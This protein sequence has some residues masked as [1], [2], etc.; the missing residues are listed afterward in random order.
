MANGD[1]N[2]LQIAT[3]GVVLSAV[4]AGLV[5][6]DSSVDDKVAMERRA[7]L[8]EGRTTAQETLTNRLEDGI[9]TE[10]ERISFF[11]EWAVYR[12]ILEH[13]DHAK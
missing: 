5:I 2:K 8:L 6:W 10:E 1:G 9:P 4:A 13:H 11:E 3:I 7:T 12:Y